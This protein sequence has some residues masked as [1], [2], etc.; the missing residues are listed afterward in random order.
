MRYRVPTTFE[1]FNRT[2]LVRYA[3]KKELRT[4]AWHNEDSIT[5]AIH[6]NGDA[7]IILRAGLGAECEWHTFLHELFH[8]IFDAIGHYDDLGQDEVIVDM[9]AASLHHFLKTKRG[10]LT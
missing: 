4:K 8:A 3:T 7:T 1:M 10:K 2:Y 6:S 5:D 9:C